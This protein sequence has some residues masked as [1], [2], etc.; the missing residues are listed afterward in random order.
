MSY[1][2]NRRRLSAANDPNAVLSAL[3][4]PGFVNY[5][6]AFARAEGGERPAAPLHLDVDVTTACNFHCPMCPAGSTGHN[7]PGFRKGRFMDRRLYSRVLAEAAAF[8]LPSLR[9]GMTGEPLLI[10]NIAAWVAEAREAGVLDISLI[11]N[12]RLLTPSLSRDLIAAGLTR[13][14]ISVDAGT[15]ETYAK[16]RPG[17]DWNLLLHN[18]LGFLE[19]RG[20]SVPLLRIS[21]VEMSVNSGDREAFEDI[22]APLADY[23]S[24]QRYHN[25]LGAED[26]DFG[27]EHDSAPAT[28]FC[29]EPLTRLAVHVDGGLFPCCSD[30]GRQRPL[31]NL[32]AADAFSPEP[33]PTGGAS[34]PPCRSKAPL[35]HSLDAFSPKPGQTGRASPQPRRSKAPLGPGGLLA[36]WNSKE[37]NALTGPEA[38]NHEPCRSCLNGH[39]KN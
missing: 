13:L 39:P 16:V 36:V 29:A 6:R 32:S 37:A 33:G 24:F 18:I 11:T 22:F 1:A 23:L 12:G 17:G 27:R 14:M 9:L 35:G 15:P 21:F 38:A 5:R 28:G 4:G 7:F 3:L 25:I 10:P 31:G 20:G 26:T 30:F 19:A 8:G 34:L 2:I